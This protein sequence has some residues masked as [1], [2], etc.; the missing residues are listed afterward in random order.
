MITGSKTGEEATRFDF[1]QRIMR[2]TTEHKVSQTA[3]VNS[4]VHY[5]ACPSQLQHV[6]CHAQEHEKA[7]FGTVLIIAILSTVS[8]K[9][10]R[11]FLIAV[12]MAEC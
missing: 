4:V 8:C 11:Q 9:L 5:L 2:S 6:E 12:L 7:R 3:V 1:Q 10:E